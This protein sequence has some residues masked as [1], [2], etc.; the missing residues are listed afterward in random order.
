MIGFRFAQLFVFFNPFENEGF[1]AQ[2][3]LP[4]LLVVAPPSRSMAW[5]G[6]GWPLFLTLYPGGCVCPGDGC[7]G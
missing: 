1:L 2:V 6:G 4:G 7:L 5:Q 3:L